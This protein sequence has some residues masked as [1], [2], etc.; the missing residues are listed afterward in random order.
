MNQPDIVREHRRG[1]DISSDY[2]SCPCRQS[3]RR[4]LD[5]PLFTVAQVEGAIETGNNLVNARSDFPPLPLRP[6]L[7]IRRLSRRGSHEAYGELRRW[8]AFD[9]IDI[10][11]TGT[12][13]TGRRRAA[14]EL[15]LRGVAKVSIL[16]SYRVYRVPTRLNSRGKD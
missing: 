16:R 8:L 12:R 3:H 2:P 15:S 9:E 14:F 1:S 11:T 13:Q 10:S 4:V 5:A 7:F 6:S